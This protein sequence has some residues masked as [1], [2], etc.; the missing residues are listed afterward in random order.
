MIASHD[1]ITLLKL[2]SSFAHKHDETQQG[3]MAIVDHDIS[4]Y[5]GWQHGQQE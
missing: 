2:I 5:A 3:T 4:L 1:R